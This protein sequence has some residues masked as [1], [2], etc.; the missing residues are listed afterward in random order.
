MIQAIINLQFYALPQH[1]WPPPTATLLAVGCIV[2][3]SIITWYLQQTTYTYLQ[4]HRHQHR[5]PVQTYQQLAMVCEHLADM[6]CSFFGHLGDN[7][8]GYNHSKI[9]AAEGKKHNHPSRTLHGQWHISVQHSSGVLLQ[10]MHCITECEN[11][12]IFDNYSKKNGQ[13]FKP[14]CNCVCTQKHIAQMV[15]HQTP[16]ARCWNILLV[17]SKC[18][19]VQVVCHPI[20]WQISHLADVMT[21]TKCLFFLE[22]GKKRVH[23]KATG[24]VLVPSTETSIGAIQQATYNCLLVLSVY[25]A[26]F[27]LA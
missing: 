4:S 27:L 19:V 21:R 5:T 13:L 24:E 9:M 25:L 1:I 18:T 16:W 3:I 17:S 23:S 14:V 15:C 10:T 12:F 22:N 2:W 26:L 8:W 7:S 6:P 11:Q 20:V